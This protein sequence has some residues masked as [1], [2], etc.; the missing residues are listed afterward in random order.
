[1]PLPVT[2]DVE[3]YQDPEHFSH[4]DS[5]YPPITEC[6]KRGLQAGPHASSRRPTRPTRASGLDIS[7]SDPQFL[8]FAA[9]PSELQIVDR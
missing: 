5:S 6:E 2:L 1:M 8:G 3:T 9:S 7:L 4:A